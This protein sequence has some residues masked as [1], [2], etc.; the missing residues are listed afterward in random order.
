MTT[1]L[2]CYHWYNELWYSEKVIGVRQRS[3]TEELTP[4]AGSHH[5]QFEVEVPAT[6]RLY[7]AAASKM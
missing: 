3:E 5:L 6:R 4:S 2:A 7:F 1:H